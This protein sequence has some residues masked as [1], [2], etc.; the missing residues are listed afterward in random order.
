MNNLCHNNDASDEKGLN[1]T[2]GKSDK[3]KENGM[4]SL[5]DW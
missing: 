1:H 2:T 5:K 4:K 3:M